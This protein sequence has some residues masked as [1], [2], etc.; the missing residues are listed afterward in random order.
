MRVI[1][2]PLGTRGLAVQCRAV[3]G[4]LAKSGEPCAFPCAQVGEA[5]GRPSHWIPKLLLSLFSS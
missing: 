5:W 4:R 2:T 3:G 1:L